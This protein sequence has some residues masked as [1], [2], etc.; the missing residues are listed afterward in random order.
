MIG[1]ICEE[2][3]K[4]KMK[5]LLRVTFADPWF[6]QTFARHSFFFPK[7]MRMCLQLLSSEIRTTHVGR[8][9]RP[10]EGQRTVKTQNVYDVKGCIVI[11]KINKK[12]MYKVMMQTVIK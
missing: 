3:N 6:K 1:K 5:Y 9:P 10:I 4:G 7:F 12:V 11:L 2:V 8:S